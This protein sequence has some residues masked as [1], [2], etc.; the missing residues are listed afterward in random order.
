MPSSSADTE[1]AQSDNK[2]KASQA[3]RVRS[4][5][6]AI[7][8][9]LGAELLIMHLLPL[10][11]LTSME[12]AAVLDGAVLAVVVVVTL[13]F[14]LF[15][16]MVLSMSALKRAQ[17]LL[18]VSE[19]RYRRFFET[20][21]DGILILD[22]DTGEITDVNPF[23]TEM[24]GYPPAEL[25]GKKFCEASA[26]KD[27]EACKAAF[28]MLRSEGYV[29]FEHLQVRPS[30]GP[31]VDVEFVSNAYRAD[32]R[33]VIQCNLR[34]ISERERAEQEIRKLASFPRESPDP[35]LRIAVGTT[36]LYANDAAAP[37]L[38]KWNCKVGECL[39]EEHW[40]VL[41]GVLRDGRKA[42]AEIECEGRTFIL[43][44]APFSSAGYVNVYGR[45][46]TER[47][48]AEENLREAHR[49]NSQI[50]ESIADGFV[51]FDRE[52]RYT[53]VNAS[54]AR[55]LGMAPE[56]LLGRSVWEVWPEAA[57]L[58][59][60]A[61]F[62]RAVAE[63]AVVQFEERYPA[64]LEKWFECRCYPAA[65]GLSVFF[66]D[67][68]GRKQAEERLR[69]T[70]EQ[71]RQSQKM[72]AI[73]QLAGGVA[74]EFNNM[75]FVINGQAELILKHLPE[76]DPLRSQIEV[77]F[78][79]GNRLAKLTR[80]ILAFSRR[81]TLQPRTLDLNEIVADT[82]KL[83]EALIHKNITVALV[84]G[85][86]LKP[87]KADPAQMG[88][89]LV[90]LILNARDAMPQGG[91]LTIE[92][93]NRELDEAYCRAH[94]GLTPGHYVML[95]VSD[96]GCGMD[97]RVKAHLFEPFFTTKDVGQGTGLGLASV[98][99]IVRQSG[100]G[101]VVRSAP[102]QGTTF[103]VYLPQA[104]GE[105]A[106]PPRPAPQP[107][108]RGTET[109][110]MVEDEAE[111][112]IIACEMLR[113]LGYT[114]VGA[115]NG[116]EALAA[117]ERHKEKIKMVITDVVMPEMSGPELVEQL[118]RVRPDIKVLFV[119]GYADPVLTVEGRANSRAHFLP[120]PVRLG[121]LARKVRE[122]LDE[123]P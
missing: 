110:L 119:S 123:K 5:I 53:Y 66:T 4:L 9:I 71:L 76:Y 60:G 50:L 104:E 14:T 29:R 27:V 106:W 92:T 6:V 83:L 97:E 94:P 103:K 43:M 45:D 3:S 114:V 20:A 70:Q 105:P 74:H 115:S 64:P 34:D 82:S 41:A 89:V 37:L 93:T 35:V 2:L 48:R 42:E 63:K 13:Y 46:I 65:E 54:A 108:P 96:T 38:R 117:F 87:V 30:N 107:V 122:V 80:Q 36:V 78:Q 49:R 56:Q 17:E 1:K 73:G 101:I 72:E 23:L 69:K 95:A 25:L 12:T 44:W 51:A 33:R 18:Q 67:V 8:A 21:Q 32:H 47:K 28:Q 59:F 84:P 31:L 116:A 75:L 26:F 7:A 113:A 111:V 40:E 85:A 118:C 81:Q 77:I 91:K 86:K 109:V 90:N 120:K 68:S 61:E 57:R 39:P 112:R 99:G 22:A 52:W 102:G 16:P 19:S 58:R 11:K 79:T 15:R 55:F 24:L 88:E 100:G 121:A 10:L 98:Y 62:R